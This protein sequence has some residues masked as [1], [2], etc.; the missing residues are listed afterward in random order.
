MRRQIL[1]VATA[2][3]AAL[4]WSASAHAA[5]VFFSDRAAFEAAAGG[6]LSFEGFETPW[7][8]APS[9]AF[10]G[11]TLSETSGNPNSII[12]VGSFPSVGM[13][14]QGSRWAGYQ[15]NGSSVATFAF[16]SPINALGVDYGVA[17][18]VTV[19]VGGD[20]ITS[21]SVTAGV[22]VFFGVIDT[23]GTFTTISFA[24]GG[25]KPDAGFDA[26]SFGTKVPEPGTLALLGLGL[27]GLAA[28]R[29]RKK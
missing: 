17:A 13:P 20:I 22:P 21:F 11:F 4:L 29:R 14:T 7:T 24:A 19:D 10:S 25:G 23:S 6:G 15:D 12:S 26:L 3:V 8:S 18:S 16:A 2:S 5:L 1:K 28:S 9:V 27:A